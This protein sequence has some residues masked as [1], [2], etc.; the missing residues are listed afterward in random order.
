[1]MAVAALGIG[2]ATPVMAQNT[3]SPPSSSSEVQKPSPGTPHPP[4][5]RM[6]QA[7]PTM[8][9]DKKQQLPPTNRMGEAVP[10]MKPGDP[11]SGGGGTSPDP[12]TR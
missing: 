6:D 8:K 5:N 4:E 2:A 7:T 3:G 12:S 1:M 10:P 11:P 9:S